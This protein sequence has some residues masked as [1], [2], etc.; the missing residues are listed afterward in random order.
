MIKLLPGSHPR[1]FADAY[2][3]NYYVHGCFRFMTK[4]VE[5]KDKAHPWI[6]AVMRSRFDHI[7][8]T[9]FIVAECDIL[10]DDSYGWYMPLIDLLYVYAR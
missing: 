9:L 2:D 7:P 10:R 6:A 5:E 4:V 8:P 1:T 3:R